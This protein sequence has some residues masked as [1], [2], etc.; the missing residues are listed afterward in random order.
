MFYRCCFQQLSRVFLGFF[1]VWG[2]RF[3]ST[4]GIQI[5]SFHG[6]FRVFLG[7]FF[8]FFLGLSRV[9]FFKFP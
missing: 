6:I 8:V 3:L 7:V 5:E 9:V 2:G 4:L 1:S